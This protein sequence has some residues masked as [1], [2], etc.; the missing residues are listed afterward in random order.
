MSGVG[1]SVKGAFKRGTPFLKD[2]FKPVGL[3]KWKPKDL[4][5]EFKDRTENAWAAVNPKDTLNDIEVAMTPDN[6]AMEQLL[7]EQQAANNK[8]EMP[9]PDEEEIRRA[10]RRAGGASRSGRASTI[11]SGGA[12]GQGLGG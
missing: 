2:G 5:K 1:K 7:A 3:G 11:M 6:S 8:P 4:T 9:M 12:G 10:R